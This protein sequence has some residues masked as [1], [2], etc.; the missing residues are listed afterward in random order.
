[1]RIFLTYASEQRSIAEQV[2]YS[3]R[4][5]GFDVFL[6]KDDLPP[7]YSY[8]KQIETAIE[9]SDCLVFLIS[10][11]SVRL[12]RYT[13]TELEFARQKWRNPDGHVLPVMVERTEMREVP[14]F[15]RAVTIL[16]PQGNIAAEVASHV[17]RLVGKA[18]PSSESRAIYRVLVG[19]LDNLDKLLNQYAQTQV[20]ES[21]QHFRPRALDQVELAVRRVSASRDSI[22]ML[23]DTETRKELDQICD[24]IIPGLRYIVE[25]PEWSDNPG[26]RPHV[27]Y[28]AVLAFKSSIWKL[29]DRLIQFI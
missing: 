2:A 9:L 17:D 8:D 26:A 7:G 23:G 22:S 3:L 13:R 25:S 6:D 24:N 10:P 18:G 27:S 12:R 5:R 11:Q 28:V 4:G 1:M 14:E 20:A 15:L 16:E 21:S 29:R 19:N